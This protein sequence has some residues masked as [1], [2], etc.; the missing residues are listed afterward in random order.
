MKTFKRSVL[1]LLLLFASFSSAEAG[2]SFTI[3]TDD[4]Y[5]SVG[6]YDYLPYAFAASPSY[7][8]QRISFYDALSDYGYWVQVRRLATLYI[9]SLDLDFSWMVLAGIRT[10]GMACLPLR[11]LDLEL[12]IW[13]ELDPGL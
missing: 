13:M 8:P 9:W 2:V 1:I 11:T 3:G 10:L 4:F 12:P 7:V 5:L 6:D